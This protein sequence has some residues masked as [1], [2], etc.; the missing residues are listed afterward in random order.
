MEKRIT[1]YALRYCSECLF[2]KECHPNG[3]PM[4]EYY[5]RI[6]YAEDYGEMEMLGLMCEFEPI[7]K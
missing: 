2:Q 7:E 5:D 1:P 6:D 3:L 4:R